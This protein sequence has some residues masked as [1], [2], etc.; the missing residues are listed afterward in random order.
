MTLFSQPLCT[1]AYFICI[2]VFY[3][4]RNPTDHNDV[5]YREIQYVVLK[6]LKVILSVIILISLVSYKISL[7]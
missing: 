5:S 4:I 7:E 6:S 1:E 2:L 3:Y